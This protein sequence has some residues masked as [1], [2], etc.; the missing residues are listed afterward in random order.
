MDSPDGPTHINVLWQVRAPSPAPSCDKENDEQNDKDEKQDLRNR[1]G[2][3]R[4][5]KESK[6]CGNYR[7]N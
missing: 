1:G 6:H 5:S 4:N 7:D 2:R 3:S